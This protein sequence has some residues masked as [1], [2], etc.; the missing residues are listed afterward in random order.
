MAYPESSY[1]PAVE[2]RPATADERRTVAKWML[3]FVA[4]VALA[5]ALGSLQMYQASSE[6]TAKE[7][8]QRATAALTE[9]DALLER[10]YEEMQGQAQAAQ[11]DDT[12]AL[13][14][15]PIALGLTK[16]DV[17]G[18]SKGELRSTMLERSADRLY[19]NGTGVLRESAGA[20]GSGGMFSITGI[21]DRMLGQLTEKNHERYAIATVA[22]FVVAAAMCAATTAACRGWGR[23]VAPALV[24]AAAGAAVLVGGLAVMGYAGAQGGDYVRTEFFGMIEELAELPVRNG[25]AC[26]VAGVTIGAIG[27][28]GRI[29]T[30]RSPTAAEYG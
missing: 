3:G 9:I 24:L 19:E 18:R 26:L 12:V 23:L 27:A 29:F 15:Y 30:R 22:L 4:F 21:T 17:Q 6:G 25:V 13:E 11:A 28:G 14:D 10:R 20:K 5:L 16:E 1:R 8:L 2:H 7:S